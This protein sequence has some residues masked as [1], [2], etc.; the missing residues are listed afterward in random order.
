VAGA[1]D[2]AGGAPKYHVIFSE[3][4]EGFE[5]RWVTAAG[6]R[7]HVRCSV[8][9]REDG[10]PV[11]LAHGLGVS[12]RHWMRAGRL[13]AKNHPVFAPDPPGTG[14]S[15]RPRRALS[16]IQLADVLAACM[17]ELGTGAAVVL[18]VS[19]G[20]QIA[21]DLAVHH[22]AAAKAVVLIAPT[23]D[24]SMGPAEH[25]V[26]LLLDAPREPLSLMPIVARDYFDF[27]IP[28][29]LATL[30]EAMEDWVIDEAASISV[31]ALVVRGG[32]DPIVTQEWAELFT[33]ALPKGRLE[34]I[35][36]AAHATNF[37]S[38]ERV[39]ELVEDFLG[40]LEP[41]R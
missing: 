36:G 5:S 34:V 1:V 32:R 24:P 21:I 30:N 9:G 6:Y 3:D 13:L 18:G 40:E 29:A 33:S 41:S 11:V 14:R 15:E 25:F 37:N 20:C 23:M 19:Y 2:A 22:P 12:S 7:L 10:I 17:N 35:R 8:T 28:R 4:Y 31:P 16:L 27:G 26:R 39:V 38:A